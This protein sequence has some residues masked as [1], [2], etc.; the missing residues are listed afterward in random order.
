MKQVKIEIFWKLVLCNLDREWNFVGAEIKTQIYHDI[1]D[2]K[3]YWWLF[4]NKNN[5]IWSWTTKMSLIWEQEVE[6]WLIQK[7]GYWFYKDYKEGLWLATKVSEA[8]WKNV[9]LMK[10][11]Q[12][13]GKN[14]WK[15][16]INLWK[17]LGIK[18]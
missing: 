2:W 16:F 12:G 10:W 18:K 6:D 8:T 4:D 5:C 9:I 11:W 15:S 17:K 13:G 1:K 7:R 3:S 14:I